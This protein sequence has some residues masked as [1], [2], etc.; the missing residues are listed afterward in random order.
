MKRLLLLVLALLSGAAHAQDRLHLYIWNNYLSPETIKRFQA[1]CQCEVVQDY[2][3]SVEELLAKMAAG[4]KGYDI[5]VPTGFGISP[6]TKQGLL[7][8]LNKN[9]LPNFKNQNPAFLNSP[10]DKG[11][12]YS[13][14]YAFTTTLLGFNID[15]LKA[16]NIDPSSWAIIFDPTILAKIKGKVTVLDDP[17]E[18]LAAAL[19]YNGFSANSINPAEWAKAKATILKAKPYWAA[20]NNQSYIKELTVGNI[21]VA[22]GYSSDMFQAQQDAKAAKRKF[23]I[24]YTLQKEGNTLSVDSL[25]VPKTAPRPDLAHKFINFMLEGKNAADLTNMVG[26]GNPNAAAEQYVKPELRQVQAIFPTKAQMAKLE[27]LNDLDSKNRRELNRLWTYIKT[28]K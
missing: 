6:L 8:P 4:A 3:G 17:R 9:Q 20:F 22:H 2:Y 1:S 19:K 25:V 5:L 23:S 18:L 27:Q 26:T 21:W 11:N 16:L 14:P 12:T 28:Q 13:V 24:G 7:Q 15:K 10:F